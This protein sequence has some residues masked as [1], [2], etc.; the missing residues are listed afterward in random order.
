MVGKNKATYCVSLNSVYS[1]LVNNFDN[2][3]KNQEDSESLGYKHLKIHG[4]ELEMNIFVQ[5]SLT[6][7]RILHILTR[8]K[9]PQNTTLALKKSKY[10]YNTD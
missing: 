2:H 5:G 4:K 8:V 7:I 6:I 3:V 1:I 9:H 10:N